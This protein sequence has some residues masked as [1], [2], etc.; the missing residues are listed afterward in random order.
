MSTLDTVKLAAVGAVV[1]F[2]G[3]LAWKA[4]GA[5]GR[6]ADAVGDALGSAANTV[7]DVL[8]TDLNPT[9]DQNLAYRG[10]NAVVEVIT[11]REDETIG[12]WWWELWNGDAFAEALNPPAQSLPNTAYAHGDFVR[13]ERADAAYDERYGQEGAAF[14]VWRPINTGGGASG[15]W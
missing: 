15:G 12:G 7:G 2:G 10:A 6:A 14:G 9:S 1:A 4:W 13:Q 11:G 3:V 5:A 8:A